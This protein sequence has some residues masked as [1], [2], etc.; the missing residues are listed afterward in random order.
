LTSVD[1]FGFIINIHPD[2][3]GEPGSQRYDR[4]RRV[5]KTSQRADQG[6]SGR[7][8]RSCLVK[9]WNWAAYRFRI[10]CSPR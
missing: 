9:R 1:I 10:V 6:R 2:V 8:G 7:S 4:V 3:V 5:S